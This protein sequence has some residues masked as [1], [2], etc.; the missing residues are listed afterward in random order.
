MTKFAKAS[1][2]KKL[3][4]FFP[5]R[6]KTHYMNLRHTE[7]YEVGKHNT[8]RLQLSSIPVMQTLLN[9]EE[10]KVKKRNPG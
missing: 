9:E 8:K 6:N 10:K 7:K 1:I 2:E 3:D 5:K 4:G